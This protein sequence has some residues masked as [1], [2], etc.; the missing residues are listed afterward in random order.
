MLQQMRKA[1]KSPVASVVIG[2]LV[3]A[4]AL[5][6]VADIFRG[7][8]DNVVAQVGNSQIL[9]SQYDQLL[10]NQ[11]RAFADQTKT[12]LTLEQARAMGLDRTVL[13]QAINR[14]ALDEKS[15]RLGLIA[16]RSAIESTFTGNSAFRGA[17]GAFDPLTFQRALQ[18]SGYSVE[19]FYNLTGQDIARRQMIDALV[20]GMVAPPGMVRL[21]YDLFSEQRTAEYLVVTPEEAGTV[22]EP[23]ASDL[24]AYYKAHSDQFSSPEYRAFDYVQ[25][26]PEQ[27]SGE[28]QVADADMRAEYDAHK[29]GYEKAEQR[30]IEQIA[31]PNKEAADA[32]K[33]RIKTAADFAAVARERGLSADDVKLGTF[34][35][36]RMDPRLSAVAFKVPDG[37]VTDPVQGPF[38]WV[39]LRAAKVIPGESKTFDDVKDQ[40]K[41]ELVKA[42]AGAKL[43]DVANAF[44][45]QRGSGAPITDVAMKL[46]LTVRHV[47]AADRNG[48]TPEGGR[49]EI[50]TQAAFIQQVFQTESGEES[51]LFMTDDGAS[52]AV[53][54]TGITQPSVKPLEQVREQVRE[55][56][57]ADARTKLLQTKVDGLAEQARKSTSLADVGRALRRTP[58]TSTPLRRGQTDDVFSSNLS[59]QFFAAPQGAVI[60]G[61]AA[62]GNGYVIARVAKV[63]HPEPDVSGAEYNQYRSTTAQE[64]SETAVDS[65][66]AAARKSAGV[67]V[68]Q[69]TVQRITGET[70]Q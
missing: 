45:D 53:R 21:L 48:M 46:G 4:F 3:L 19:G 23:S 41:A 47:V 8:G 69:A 38:G 70:Q 36:T 49:A 2:I 26:S 64:L 34:E 6:G 37:G 16:T 42:R 67:N 43:A 32:A 1:S 18:E 25:I 24:D 66:S 59:Q 39:I 50:P 52:Y 68:H 60:T 9:D 57:L 54:V 29:A 5:W 63:D 7:G 62:K 58:S 17:G 65:L 33:A 61:P 55:G 11:I 56:F 13:D 10:K 12:D 44:E 15:N 27:F 35:A 40:I 51:D 30:E 22:G 14:A 28:I 20:D 31:F